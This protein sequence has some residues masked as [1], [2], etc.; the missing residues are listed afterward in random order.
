MQAVEFPLD[1]GGVLLVQAASADEPSGGFG[2]AS[3]MEEKPKRA[4]ETL[5]SA[6]AHVIPALKSVTAKLRE[7]APDE[8]TVEFGLTL[9]AETGV[10][11]AKGNDEVHFAVTLA[12]SKGSG[13]AD[14]DSR[15]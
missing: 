10:I 3:A 6:L 8:V 12:W 11:V 15:A 13:S 5:E 7:L 4:A 9:T 1:D 14:G 2:L